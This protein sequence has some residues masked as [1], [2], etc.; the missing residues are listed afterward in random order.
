MQ[1]TRKRIIAAAMDM[2]ERDGVEAVSMARLA[3]DLGCG[4]VALYH[5]VPSRSALLDLVADAM[6]SA[7]EIPPGF[8][9]DWLEQVR[10]QAIGFRQV[11]LTHPHCATL[12]VGRPPTSARAMRPV[13]DALASL[14]GAGVDGHEAVRVV[15]AL[16]AYT[17]GSVLNSTGSPLACDGTAS[18]DAAEDGSHRPRLR[19]TEFPNV[20]ELAAQFAGRDPD[21]DFEFGLD[22]LVRAVATLARAAPAL[23]GERLRP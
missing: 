6:T 22:L 19:P 13:E 17:M 2:I 4:L 23:A 12:M 11:A 5:F 15:R 10:V 9:G 16:L 21:A 14:R 8:V 3:T 1:L 20:T 18:A 7:V